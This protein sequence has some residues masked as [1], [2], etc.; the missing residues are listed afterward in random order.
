MRAVEREVTD[1]RLGVHLQGER[2]VL[3]PVG[4]VVTV[5]VVGV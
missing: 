1:A 2:I 3:R 5:T 4:V